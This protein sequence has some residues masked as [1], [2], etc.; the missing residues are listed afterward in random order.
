MKDYLSKEHYWC[1]H[2]II[3][4]KQPALIPMDPYHYMTALYSFYVSLVDF[5]KKDVNNQ[6]YSE[7]D[8]FCLK[9]LK[10]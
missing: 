6:S 2:A 3:H 10:R 8:F 4:L 1:A 9:T 7:R 5:D